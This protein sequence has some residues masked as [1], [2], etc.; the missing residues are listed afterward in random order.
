MSIFLAAPN[1]CKELDSHA[2]PIEIDASDF[3]GS[4]RKG[5]DENDTDCWTSPSG[6]GF[7]IR[8]K[9]YRKDNSKVSWPFIINGI[10]KTWL[11]WDFQF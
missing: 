4:L 8:G 3:N 7:K 10:K 11:R 5:K 6:E 1:L 2:S 9:N